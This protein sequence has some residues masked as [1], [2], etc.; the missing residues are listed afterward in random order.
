MKFSSLLTWA[1]ILVLSAAAIGAAPAAAPAPVNPNNMKAFPPAEAGMV[2][3]VL[4]L[5]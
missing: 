4:P 2:R 3:Y 5:P 1:G